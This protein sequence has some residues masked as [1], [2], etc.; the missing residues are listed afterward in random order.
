MGLLF[1]YF[2]IIGLYTVT[3]TV[4]E[5]EIWV[6]LQAVIGLISKYMVA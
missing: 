2:G 4:T 3:E 1:A 6:I 5:T